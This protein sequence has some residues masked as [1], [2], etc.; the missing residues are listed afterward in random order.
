MRTTGLEPPVHNDPFLEMDAQVVNVPEELR[1]SLLDAKNNENPDSLSIM[2]LGNDMNLSQN[3]KNIRIINWIRSMRN[4][5]RRILL[6]TA[7]HSFVVSDT[8]ETTNALMEIL[9]GTMDAMADN[10]LDPGPQPETTA[11]QPETTAPQPT[12]AARRRQGSRQLDFTSGTQEAG[13]D[14]MDD[15]LSRAWTR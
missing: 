8:N 1:E 15:R 3:L 6:N 9:S 11:P 5:F 7:Q 14:N 10:I 4:T 2:F 13:Q 12:P